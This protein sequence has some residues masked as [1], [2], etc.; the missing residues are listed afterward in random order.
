V[1]APIAL[2]EALSPDPTTPWLGR[3]ALTVVAV[4][5]I[6]A[7][8]LTGTRLLQGTPH[9][10]ALQAATTAL[11]AGALVLAALRAPAPAKATAEPA[12]SPPAAFMGSFAATVAI[13]LAADAWLSTLVGAGILAVAVWWIADAARARDWDARHAAAIAGGA[14]AGRA[15]LAFTYVPVLG[16]VSAG[17]KLLHNAVMLGLVAALTI[18]A[19]VRGKAARAP[20]R[21]R[22]RTGAAR[23]ADR[24]AWRVASG[25]GSTPASRA[26]S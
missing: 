8:I 24:L 1:T 4:L 22:L 9:P 18:A 19:L 2:I 3:R 25:P 14:L 17:A 12:P 5:S 7:A 20:R 26:R 13:T 10:S 21:A 16:E 23:S 15:L 11:A 6:A